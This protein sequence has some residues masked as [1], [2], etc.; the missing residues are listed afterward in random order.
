MKEVELYKAA[1][2]KYGT[3]AQIQMV[4]EECAEL[5]LVLCHFTRNRV[6]VIDIA[7]EVA[8]VEIMCGQLRELFG[9]D[10]VNKCKKKKLI[11]LEKRLK[12]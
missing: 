6:I 3:D 11:R 2:K 5:I 8:D 4:I 10:I 7:N 12:E 9:H 1:I